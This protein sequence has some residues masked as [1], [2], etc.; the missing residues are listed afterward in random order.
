MS[1]LIQQLNNIGIPQENIIKV[2][3]YLI[4]AVTCFFALRIV[5]SRNVFHRALFLAL[6]L[7]GVACVYL[8]L[9]AEYLAV[10]QILIYVGAIVALFVFVIMLTTKIQNRAIRQL[11]SQVLISVVVTSALLCLLISIIRTSPWHKPVLPPAG[12]LNISQ[13]G[14]S[15]A[16]NYVLPFEVVSLILLA[17]L[18]GAIAIGKAKKE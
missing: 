11:N 14:R 13:L 9:G 18:V 4:A 15:L 12:L 5:I 3:F 2:T 6:T 7:I 8:Y 1:G 16:L 17:A 10:M